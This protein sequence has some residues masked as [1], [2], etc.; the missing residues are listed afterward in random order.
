MHGENK[1]E[2]DPWGPWEEKETTLGSKIKRGPQQGSYKKKNT[3][4]YR[5]VENLKR[6]CGNLTKALEF[7]TQM[8]D[9]LLKT[10]QMGKSNL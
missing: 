3:W 10:K 1:G 6:H 5:I 4:I 9:R 8:V 2:D 7:Y